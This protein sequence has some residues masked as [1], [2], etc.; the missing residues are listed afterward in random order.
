MSSRWYKLGI[1]LLDDNQVGQ[2]EVIMTD[3]NEETRQ[4]SAMLSY[5]LQTHPDVTWHDLVAGLRAPGVE[6]DELASKTAGNFTG[7][8]NALLALITFVSP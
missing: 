6:T 5:W 1:A 3:Y 7:T 2:L 8:I 4:C